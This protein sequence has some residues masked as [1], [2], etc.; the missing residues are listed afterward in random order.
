VKL[1]LCLASVFLLMSATMARP[2][3]KTPPETRNAALRYW[4]AFAEMQDPPVDVA[5]QALLGK[6]ATGEVAWDEKKLGS[7]LD[8]NDEAI[9]I[10]Q[11]ATK[12]PDCDWGLEYDEGPRASIAYAPRARALARLNTLEGMREMANGNSQGAVDTWLAGVRF[13]EHLANGGSLI[14]A[15]IAKS[16]L[17]PNLH[18][19]SIEA[20]QGH[21]SDAQKKTISVPLKQIREDGINWGAAWRFEELAGEQFFRELRSAKDP[22]ATYGKLMGQPMPSGAKAPNSEDVRN[23]REYMKA[24]QAALNMSP[25][26]AKMQLSALETQRRSLPEIAQSI[27]PNPLKTNEARADVFAAR[28]ELLEAVSS[29]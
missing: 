24:V 14:F 15:L 10:M 29:K 19:L 26:T 9:Q 13:S 1:K 16:A 23:Y 28:K 21:L 12:L 27:I 11:R 17:L 18:A 25:D 7:I 8:S 22:G 6:T 20:K 2:Q 5:I 4:I 3:A